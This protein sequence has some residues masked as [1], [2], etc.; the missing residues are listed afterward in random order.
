MTDEEISALHQSLGGRLCTFAMSIIGDFSAADDVIQEVFLALSR[1]RTISPQQPKLYLFR[2]VRNAALNWL[3]KESREAKKLRPEVMFRAP[4]GREAEKAA[5]TE[6]LSSLTPEQYQVAY[7][8]L[9]GSFSVR[10][11]AEIL[12]I[13]ES[14]TASRLRHAMDAVRAKLTV[15]QEQI[16]E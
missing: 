10:E 6:A 3:R 16:H 8:Y 5:L 15:N 12:D 9:W 11:I 7:L 2:A 1:D 4:E 13:P 14:T